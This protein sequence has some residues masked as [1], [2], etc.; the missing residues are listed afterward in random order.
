MKGCLIAIA[1]A[2]V[3]SEDAHAECEIGEHEPTEITYDC[4]SRKNSLF[5]TIVAPI[6]CADEECGVASG[7][8]SKMRYGCGN[9]DDFAGVV[10]AGSCS[11]GCNPSK[12]V[13]IP[14]VNLSGLDSE[15]GASGSGAVASSGYSETASQYMDQVP[16][17]FDRKLR[18]MKSGIDAR[19]VPQ[20]APTW[21]L[22]LGGNSSGMFSGRLVLDPRRIFNPNLSCF[23]SSLFRLVGSGRNGLDIVYNRGIR[24][25]M[26]REGNQVYEVG[27]VVV[28]RCRFK[29]IRSNDGYA[30][31]SSP[32]G[33]PFS[34]SFYVSSDVRCDLDT[35]GDY[36]PCDGATPYVTYELGFG[37][38]NRHAQ[39]YRVREVRPGVPDEVVELYC[40]ENG[41]DG[42]TYGLSRGGGASVREVVSVRDMDRGHVVT[43]RIITPDAVR[44]LAVRRYDV[45]NGR[46]VLISETRGW[47][48]EESCDFY[49]YDQEG[50]RKTRLASTGLLTEYEYDGIGRVVLE[51][52]SSPGCPVTEF[53]YSFAPLGVLPHVPEDVGSAGV[54]PDTGS[55]DAGTPRAETEV[56]DGVP[57]SKILRFVALDTM[58]HRIVEEVRLADPASANPVAFEWDNPANARTYPTTCPITG[59]SPAASC[60][61]S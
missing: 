38:T 35:H 5:E 7:E 60:R 56:V 44:Q 42:I 18:L 43:E 55:V 37:D 48:G 3:L 24:M 30:A 40:D 53:V 1:F 17:Q 19:Y 21:Y 50:R 36:V 61:R 26:V 4:C 6:T 11:H 58:N 29:G 39:A 34:V 47:G 9:F 13:E 8:V 45:V 41:T 27:E 57:V 20:G 10:L 51:R 49:T 23:D 54:G 28:D 46:D 59:A 16:L 14:L 52:R 33:F 31:F 22:S 12:Y 2:L 25:R 32:T 15:C